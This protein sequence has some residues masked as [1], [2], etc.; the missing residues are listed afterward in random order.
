MA[1]TE[2]LRKQGVG[3]GMIIS[4]ATV[5]SPTGSLTSQDGLAARGATAGPSRGSIRTEE[6]EVPAQHPSHDSSV[7]SFCR[8]MMLAFEQ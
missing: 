8:P 6:E 5:A 4:E 3:S 2:R 7:P 1:V